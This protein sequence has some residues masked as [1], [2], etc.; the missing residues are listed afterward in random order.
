M[1][2]LNLKKVSSFWITSYAYFLFKIFLKSLAKNIKNACFKIWRFEIR[3]FFVVILKLWMFFGFKIFTKKGV[4]RCENWSFSPRVPMGFKMAVT[5]I[6]SAD[7]KA[8]VPA[9]QNLPAKYSFRYQK[10]YFNDLN[11]PKDAQLWVFWRRY[12]ELGQ[13][14]PTKKDDLIS[15]FVM[16]MPSKAKRT[17]AAFLNS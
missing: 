15:Y 4:W 5:K 11:V 9:A 8:D 10:W 17:G 13:K 7:S 1:T 16:K 14:T 2:V 12:Y 6:K 3:N